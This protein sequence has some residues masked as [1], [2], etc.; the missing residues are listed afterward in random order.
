MTDPE[1][2]A[3][4]SQVRS[5]MSAAMPDS[6]VLQHM[7]DDGLEPADVANPAILARYKPHARRPQG[8]TLSDMVAQM[9]AGE[10]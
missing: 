9:K 5:K 10:P 3:W 7:Y 4:L 8:Q 6:H 1:Y 2:A